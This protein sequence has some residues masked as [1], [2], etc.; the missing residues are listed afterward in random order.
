MNE[1]NYLIA[2]ASFVPF[3]PARLRLLLSYFS[4]ARKV[5]NLSE[6]SLMEVGL[7][8][9]LVRGFLAYK[10]KFKPEEYFRLLKK[11]EIK[12]IT[13]DDPSYPVNLKGLT[14]A[15]VVLY[16]KGDIIPNDTNAV[17][18]VGARKMTVYGKEVTEIFSSALASLGVTIVSGLAI[19][20]D[21]VAHRAALESGG[22]TIAVMGCGLDRLYPPQN[23]QLAK[24]IAASGALLSEY[25]LGYPAL[26]VNFA[27]RN[28]IISG[29]SRALLVVEGAAKSGTLLTASHAAE[30][31][32]VVFAVPGPIT[33][34]LS[35]A[36]NFLIKNG[37]KV[38]DGP[39]EILRE[40]NLQ[41]MV[42]IG[43]V[44]KVMP[45]DENE[46]QI[47]KLITDEPLHLDE[48]AR[49]SSLEV[50]LLSARLTMME[51]K[52]LVKHLGGGVYRRI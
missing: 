32:R 16:L 14:N 37:A 21:S 31:G 40:L 42:D 11:L 2:L 1:K 9:K 49:I 33:S 15:P 23:F 30:Q 20:V 4:S 44:E 25:P 5:W 6:K 39:K 17:G 19:G 47:I 52:G 3:G 10:I 24:A 8:Q 35:A 22:R 18:I 27:V 43:E 38:A 51:L 45:A 29:V 13:E 28:R 7:G 48:I 12:V 41:T 36:P 34:P 50:G 26:P 46:T